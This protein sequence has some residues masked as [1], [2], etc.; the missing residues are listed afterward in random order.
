MKKLKDEIRSTFSSYDS[1]DASSAA[2]LQYM[3]AVLREAMRIFAPLPLGLPRVVPKGGDTVDGHFIPEGV[4]WKSMTC[5]EADIE[6][7]TVST[8]P[9]AASLS[10]KNFHDPWEFRPERWL[11]RSTGDTLEASQPFSLGVRSCMGKR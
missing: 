10:T 8:N 11:E 2:N 9:V 3:H 5:T 6:Q 4:F 7:I 1:I